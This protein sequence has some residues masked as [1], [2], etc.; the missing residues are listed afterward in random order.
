MSFKTKVFIVIDFIIICCFVFVYGPWDYAKN[1]WICTAME[2]GS[3]RYLANMFYS[4]KVIDDV[5][6]QNYLEEI[7]EDTDTSSITVGQI[8]TVGDYVDGYDKEILEHEEGQD[9]KYITFKYGDFDVH[10]IA[11]YDPTKVNA[12][13]N[14]PLYKGRI[15]SDISKE[16]NAQCAI[17]GGG[18]S[19]S[20]SKPAGLVV[21]DGKV[22]YASS[23]G[24]NEAAALTWDG[25]LI[26]GSFRPAD[27]E[28]KNI[29]EALTFWPALIVNGKAV[30]MK[31]NGGSGQNPRTVIAQRKDGVILFL[32]V[33]GY[34][35]R[36]SYRGRGGVYYSDLITILQRYKAYT[37]INMDGG[38][39]S[40]MVIN[41][42]L[43]NDP[44][45]PQREGQDFIR[46]AWYLA[47]K[48]EGNE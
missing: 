25:K 33:N 2:T 35:S 20:N 40:T 26:Y 37:A 7:N 32:V 45:E 21:H 10:L 13:Y 12:A 24:Y 6:S 29:K 19:W 28:S 31:G 8:E 3:H 27:I 5:M 15:L 47:P 14:N 16:V 9:F 34:G 46:S 4:Q 42:K 44:C 17:N 18:Y 43:V 38:S 41:H 11:I 23:S 39:S 48:A 30:S 22:V 1:F 36:L